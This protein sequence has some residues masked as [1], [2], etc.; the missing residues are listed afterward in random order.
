VR[1]AARAIAPKLATIATTETA[2][3]F[4]SE[5]HHGL[6]AGLIAA[7]MFKRWDATLDHK[8]CRLCREMDGKLAL[9]G[10]AWAGGQVPGKAHPGCRCLATAIYMP[11]RL[12]EAA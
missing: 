7:Q 9:L 3:A 6:R 2:H 10:G 11:K 8:T 12:Q 5:R 4:N 1:E